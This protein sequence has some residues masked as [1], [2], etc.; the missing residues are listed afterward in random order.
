LKFPALFIRIQNGYRVSTQKLQIQSINDRSV[1][2][3]ACIPRNA[4]EQGV[5]RIYY[6]EIVKGSWFWNRKSEWRTKR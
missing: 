1:K 3:A 5:E 6:K 2:Q 4:E